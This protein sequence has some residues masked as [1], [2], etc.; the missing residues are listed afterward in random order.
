[1]YMDWTWHFKKERKLNSKK[2]T[3]NTFQIEINSVFNKEDF[4]FL[5]N[6]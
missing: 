4:F 3:K 5:Q 2:S 6:N 1:M